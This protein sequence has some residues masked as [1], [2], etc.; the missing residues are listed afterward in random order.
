MRLSRA[1]LSISLTA[2]LSLPFIGS[3]AA[4]A[5][6][7]LSGYLV[8]STWTA[9]F[10]GTETVD[11]SSGAVTGTVTS[12]QQGV[13]SPNHQL[14]AYLADNGPC[15]VQPEG[16]CA[17]QPDLMLSSSSGANPQILVHAIQSEDGDAY[18]NHPTWSPNS[19]QIYFDSPQ[20]IGRINTD[21]TG[22]ESLGAGVDP[23]ISPD[24]S[25]LS[26]LESAP[27]TAPDGTTQYGM[28]LYI[29]D[30]STQSVR[31]LAADYQAQSTPPRWS[32]DGEHIVYPTQSGLDV[33]DVATGQVTGIYDSTTASVQI[34]DIEGPVYSSDGTQIAFA[35]YDAV[36][37]ADRLYAVAV[38]GSDLRQIS[39]VVGT[40]TEWIG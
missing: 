16:G 1:A 36:S 29:L 7:G 31:L 12:G 40:P 35:G 6:T 15:V 32:P 38:D 17:W 9:G 2:T 21:G 10:N 24:G 30:L 4:S 39:D 27:Y 20:G 22:F 14:L 13:Y 23:A 37:G 34:A 25:R 11:A 8:V 28:N 18:V 26:Y 5:S 33:A 3:A 19:K